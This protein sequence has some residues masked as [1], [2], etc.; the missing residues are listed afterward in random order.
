MTHR[1]YQLRGYTTS[2][3]YDL[4]DAVLRQC[5]VLYNAALEEWKGAYKQAGVSRTYYDQ[6]KEFTLIRQDDPDMW[7]A[8][9]LHIGRG[10]LRRLD[11]ARQ[12]FFRRVKTGDVPGYPRFK[13]GR[14]WN[15]IELS[16]VSAAMVKEAGCHYLVR[17]KGLPVIRLKH[18]RDLPDAK[19]L[20]GLSITR[21]GRRLFVNLTYEMAGVDTPAAALD[22]AKTPATS[23]GSAPRST[24]STGLNATVGIDLG[25][26]DRVVLSTGE[27]IPRRTKATV[28]IERAQQRLSRCRKGSGRWRE[29]RAILANILH[30]ERIANRNECHRITTDLVRRFRTIATEDLPIANMMRSAKGTIENPGRNVRQK[31]GLNRSIAEQTWGVILNQLRYKAEWAGKSFVKVEASY[32]SQTCSECGAVDRDYRRGKV[33]SCGSCG[34]TMDADVNAAVNIMNRGMAA[35]NLAAAAP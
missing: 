1:T 20:K 19:C 2:T 32:T 23:L 5:A 24:E 35:G 27:S 14:H 18:N 9:S 34:N 26:T 4:L 7:G 21:R 28:R 3:G 12:A 6:T 16:D 33:Y 22:A 10:V 11:R 29:R 15:T 25:V 13:S 8:L 30:R 31:A 17:V